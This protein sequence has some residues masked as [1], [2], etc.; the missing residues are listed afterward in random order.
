M[1]LSVF[2]LDHTLLTINSSYHFG[3][4]LYRQKFF[5]FPSLL[6]SLFYYARHKLFGLS[7]Q[8]LHQKTFQ[9]LFKGVSIEDLQAY[10]T[11]FL[12]QQLTEKLYQP[13]LQRLHEAQKRGDYTLILSSSPD[14][15]VR[16]I[17]E[18]FGV[19]SWQATIYAVDDGGCLSHLASIL[20]GQDKANY[21]AHLIREMGIHSSSVTVYSDSHLDLPI[22]KMAGKAIGVVPDFYLKRICQEKG[23]EII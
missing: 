10:V 18:W 23:W 14:F 12:E 7:I 22:L 5:S 4:Y 11:V 15:L 9:L 2:D 16:P 13:A 3:A 17:A 6:A 1:R 21:L 20:E 19:D 8:K